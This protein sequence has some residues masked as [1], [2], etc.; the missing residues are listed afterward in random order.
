MS[1]L[2]L[3][4]GIAGLITLIVVG[5][6]LARTIDK[7]RRFDDARACAAAAPS[8][9]KPL[10]RCDPAIRLR[11]EQAR[12]GVACEAAI[13]SLNGPRPD[14]YALQLVCGEQ[15]KRLHA[16]LDAARGD[17]ADVNR[18]LAE[19]RTT[20]AAAVGRA[21]AR[22][23]LLSDRKAQSDAAIAAAPR[24]GDGRV[25]CDAECL[26]RLAGD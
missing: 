14:G 7:A 16:G 22:A 13:A 6:W 17:L 20:T 24:T 15:V 10:D 11:I 26:R 12:A 5:I 4:G 8:T 3:G 2:K 1:W 19:A 23:V 18:Q 21:E 25:S 9:D